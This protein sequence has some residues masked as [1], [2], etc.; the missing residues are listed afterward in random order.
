MNAIFDAADVKIEGELTDYVSVADSGN[1]MHR[2]FCPRC[3]TPLISA[4][5]ARPDRVVIRVGA[6]DDRNTVTPDVAIWTKSAP[7]WACLDPTIPHEPAQ[8]APVK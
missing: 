8:P 2:R 7:S 3:G 5:E 4:S 6:L 1:V